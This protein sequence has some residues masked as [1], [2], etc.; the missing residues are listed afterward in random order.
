MSEMQNCNMS[1]CVFIMSWMTYGFVINYL[2]QMENFNC[3]FLKD[4]QFVVSV[5]LQLLDRSR[6][7]GH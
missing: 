3:A 4:D 1:V 7:A 2:V 5:R 6:Q